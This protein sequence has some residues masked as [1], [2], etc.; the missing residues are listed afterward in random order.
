MYGTGHGRD[1]SR[2]EGEENPE[3]EALREPGEERTL[4]RLQKG[5]RGVGKHG[6]VSMVQGCSG[7]RIR[8]VG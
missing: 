4:T 8:P 3:A 6:K 7:K 1:L 5:K 2:S